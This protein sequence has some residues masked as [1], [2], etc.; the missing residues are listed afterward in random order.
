MITALIAGVA[1]LI[2]ERQS[3]LTAAVRIRTL[4]LERANAELQHEVREREEAEAA[5]RRHEEELLHSQKM[6][7][8]GTLA[9]GIAHDFNNVLTAIIGFSGLALDR[10]NDLAQATAGQEDV[11]G[12]RD[13]IREITRA[14]EHA[15]VVT[16]QLLSFSR[17]QVLQPE[18]LDL[19]AVVRET[20]LL[21]QRLIGE[22]VRVETRID[23]RLSR[24]HADRG[25]VTQVIVNL[26]VNARDAMPDGGKLT[27]L[28]TGATVLEASKLAM[29][30]VPTGR[31]VEFAVADTGCGIAP[32]V[33]PRIF[34]PFFTTKGLGKGTGLGL[35]TVYGI[36]LRLGGRVIVDSVM[37]R[38]TTVRV[39]FPAHDEQEAVGA[40]AGAGA[41]GKAETILLVEDEAGVRQLATRVLARAG[42][43]VIAAA[44]GE[45]A[46]SLSA[47][48]AGRVDLL[49][50]DLVMPGISGRTTAERLHVER[51]AMRILFMS[52]YSDE[53]DKLRSADG[54]KALLIPKPFTAEILERRVREALEAP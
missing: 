2:V 3:R 22:R 32:E 16:N 31:Y 46:L 23:G 33:L 28:V 7:A 21:L 51:P 37:G 25:Q 13:D 1:F 4:E 43:E 20:E 52:G 18:S 35:S 15:T 14:A 27:L 49:L 40:G 10:V 30:G 34:E 39:F 48:Y 12:L 11:S 42:F 8:L 5:L 45:E 19:G 50:T 6:E 44:S 9:G 26:A 17:K 41:T 53:A 29:E 38:G 36:V 54:G 24:I 47:A